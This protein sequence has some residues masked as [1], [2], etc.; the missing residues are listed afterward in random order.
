MHQSHPHSP[1]SGLFVC[2]AVLACLLVT[3]ASAWIYPEHRDI[4]FLA[5]QKLD[6]GRRA[7]LDKLWVDARLGHESRLSLVPADSAQGE[8]T[9]TIDYAAWPAIAGDH[10]ISGAELLHGGKQLPEL[11]RGNVYSVAVSLVIDREMN[12]HHT[13]AELFD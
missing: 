11:L 9:T 12:R 4:T 5:I 10:S 7:V 1:V 3:T 6:P 8:K 13:Y 2:L